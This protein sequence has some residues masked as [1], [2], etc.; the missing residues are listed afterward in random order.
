MSAT[1]PSIIPAI[2]ST[3]ARL[4]AAGDDWEGAP[5]GDAQDPQATKLNLLTIEHHHIGPFPQTPDHLRRFVVPGNE[6]V[7]N[8]Q[9]LNSVDEPQFQGGAKIRQV[10]SIND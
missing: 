8:P 9:L 1:N 3:W 6:Q 4:I 5:I 2:C 7:R 10:P